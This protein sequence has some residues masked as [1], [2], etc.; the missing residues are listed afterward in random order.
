VDGSHFF[1]TDI[2]VMVLSDG[3]TMR[4]DLNLSYAFALTSV[5]SDA[6]S[7]HPKRE[8]P[9]DSWPV[10]PLHQYTGREDDASLE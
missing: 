9:G 7:L 5:R 2:V 8:T 10:V 3:P 6:E 1:L 4:F